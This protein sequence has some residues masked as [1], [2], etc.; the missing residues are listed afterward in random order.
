MNGTFDGKLEATGSFSASQ[1]LG[2]NYDGTT[3]VLTTTGDSDW[4]WTEPKVEYTWNSG[5]ISVDLI[6]KPEVSANEGAKLSLYA[7]N[8]ATNNVRY[9]SRVYP[10]FNYLTMSALAVG[11]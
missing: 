2:W 5:E 1:E 3:E 7:C 4:S 10:S 9:V 11:V 8:H 6:L